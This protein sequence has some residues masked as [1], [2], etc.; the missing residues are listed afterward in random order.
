MPG[1]S[2]CTR[3][4]LPITTISTYKILQDINPWVPTGGRKGG[5]WWKEGG[6]WREEGGTSPLEM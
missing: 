1:L 5:T 2:Q 4:P 3:H 6:T